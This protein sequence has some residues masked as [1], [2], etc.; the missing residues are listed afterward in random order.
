[1]LLL[2]LLLLLLFAGGP[3]P[4]D[5]SGMWLVVKELVVRVAEP[6]LTTFDARIIGEIDRALTISLILI[7]TA[8]VVVGELTSASELLQ[9]FG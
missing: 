6:P 5:D 8:V 2:P 1:M 7:A 3:T 9:K 4:I